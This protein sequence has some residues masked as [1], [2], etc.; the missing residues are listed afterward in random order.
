[1]QIIQA[2]EPSHVAIVR[3]LMREYQQALDVDLCFQNF[4]AE[5][6][7]LPGSYT[8]PTGRLLLAMHDGSP[9]GCVALH[10]IDSTR[11]EMKRLYVRPSARGLGVGRALIAEVLE[12]AQ[13]IGY[14]EIVLDTLPTM[15]EAQRL[16]EQFGFSDIAS[17]RPNPIAGTRYLGKRL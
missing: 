11:C 3:E 1:M 10:A 2:I 4:E 6:R 16:Y 9:V 17:Y 7:N 14:V 12:A 15:I 8:P 13:H 5:L